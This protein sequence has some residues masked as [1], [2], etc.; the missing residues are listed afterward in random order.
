MKNDFRGLKRK[1]LLQLVALL[2]LTGTIGTLASRFVIDGVLQAPFANGFIAFCKKVLQLDH[3]TAMNLYQQLLRNN[4]ELLLTGGYIVL[5]FVFFYF[6]LSRFMRY[7]NQINDGINRLLDESEQ[8]IVLASELKFMETRLNT[9]KTT[10][11]QRKLAAIESEQR[12]NDL[13]VYLAHD[14]KTPLTSVIGYL[15]LLEEAPDMPMEQRIKYTS[16]SLNKALR[17]EELINEF[18]EITRYNHNNM[19]LEP[20]D[21]KLPIMLE[22]LA[23]EMYPAMAMKNLASSVTADEDIIIYGDPNKLARVFMNILRNAVSYSDENST[24]EIRA[25]RQDTNKVDITFR[26]KG[27]QIPQHQLDTIFEKFF[28]LDFARSSNTGGAGLG[29][30]I[31][32]EIVEM[33]KGA[34]SAQSSEECTEFKVT[35]PV[36]P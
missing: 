29:L 27:R 19:V 18:F 24:I 10:L 4:K 20:A 23:D 2:A 21:I 25:T 12:K 26:N 6:S 14:L 3:I 5:L 13:V 15:S 33:H 16:V 9:I 7:F 34:I 36:R 8:P 11:L 28:R 35:L 32:R 31:A 30:A 1:I 22:Q 17:L